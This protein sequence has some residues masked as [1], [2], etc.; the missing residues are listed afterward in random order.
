VPALSTTRP[1][2]PVSLLTNELL[3]K[4]CKIVS[5]FCF[6]PCTHSYLRYTEKNA[7]IGRGARKIKETGDLLNNETT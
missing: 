7:P 3:S 5:H 1:F 4:S 2:V 6:F